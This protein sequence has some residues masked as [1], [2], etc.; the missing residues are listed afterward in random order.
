MRGR[1]LGWDQQ[2]CWKGQLKARKE[3]ERGEDSGEGIGLHYSLRER[4]SRG[5]G[6]FVLSSFYDFFIALFLIFLVSSSVYSF[7]NSG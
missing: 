1:S 3:E 2:L 7:V 6:S 5:P 4:G